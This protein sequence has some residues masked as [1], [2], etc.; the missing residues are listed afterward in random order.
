MNKPAEQI[1]EVPKAKYFGFPPLGTNKYV[2]GLESISN[3]VDEIRHVHQAHWDETEVLYLDRPMNPDYDLFMAKEAERQFVL[4]TVRDTNGELIGDLG[5][6]LGLSTHHEGMLQ[7]KEDFFFINKQ[8]RKSG[9]ATQLLQY[10]ETQLKELGVKLIG[11]SDKSP[12]GG[13]SL[14]PF[15][16]REGYKK[17]AIAYVK[18]V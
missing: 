12:C 5:Y 6:F 17:V 15:L 11:M 4:F 14:E 18:E 1:D 8:H 10:A 7:A 3:I 13:K 2:I 16:T 9:I